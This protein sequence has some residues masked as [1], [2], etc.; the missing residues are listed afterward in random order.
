MDDLHPCCSVCKLI[1]ECLDRAVLRKV[2]DF[3]NR[4]FPGCCPVRETERIWG[5]QKGIR[6][7]CMQYVVREHSVTGIYFA[8][9]SRPTDLK[10]RQMLLILLASVFMSLYLSLEVCRWHE[11][12]TKGWKAVGTIIVINCLSSFGKACYKCALKRTYFCNLNL[13]GLELYGYKNEV[14]QRSGHLWQR[15]VRVTGVGIAIRLGE[16][17]VQGLMEWN[18]ESES[19]T[20]QGEEGIWLPLRYERLLFA[21][22]EHR[23]DGTDKEVGRASIPVDD[24]EDAWTRLSTRTPLS[25]DVTSLPEGKLNFMACITQEE[26]ISPM[27]ML[28]ALLRPLTEFLP[29]RCCCIMLCLPCCAA[30]WTLKALCKRKASQNKGGSAPRNG[31]TGETWRLLLR[32]TLVTLILAAVVQFFFHVVE[33]GAA[34]DQRVLEGLELFLTAKALGWLVTEPGA[35]SWTYWTMRSLCPVLLPEQGLEPERT[36][37]S[38]A[39]ASAAW[40]EEFSER[41]GT[42]GSRLSASSLHVHLL[43][44]GTASGRQPVPVCSVQ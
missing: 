21:I 35:L 17:T 4:I 33:E 26:L 12:L 6:A 44:S 2:A 32:L 27:A 39:S 11:E 42:D 3:L 15:S 24:D 23:S 10:R 38:S 7:G 40:P 28:A 37:F 5:K 43:S 31:L 13:P 1:F 14:G 16:K 25:L 29:L 34:A 18:A 20:Y 22:L 30:W 9:K 8:P 41:K 19:W 36:D